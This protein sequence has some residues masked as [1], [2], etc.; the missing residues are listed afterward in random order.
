MLNDFSSITQRKKIDA[1]SD[2]PNK[3]PVK[4]VKEM[5]KHRLDKKKHM[6]KDDDQQAGEVCFKILSHSLILCDII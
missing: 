2:P 1:V 6:Q 5:I 3:K 4:D